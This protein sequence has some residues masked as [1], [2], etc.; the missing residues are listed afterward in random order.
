MTFDCY[1]TLVNF[2]MARAITEVFGDRLPADRVE[3]FVRL[4]SAFRFDEVLGAWK[5]YRDVIADATSRAA[6]LMGI[7]YRDGDGA[8]LYASIG[9]WGPH[10]D[11]PE[12]LRTVATRVPLVIMS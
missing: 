11:V 5:P 12:A 9:T 10:P 8:R 6:R 3:R 7:E 1:G 2:Q 4:A